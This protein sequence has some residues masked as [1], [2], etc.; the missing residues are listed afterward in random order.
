MLYVD[1]SALLKFY[2]RERGTDAMI[3]RLGTRQ[4]L[5]SSLLTFAEVHNTLAK[6]FLHERPKGETHEQARRA[7][8]AARDAFQ[9]DWMFSLNVVEMTT[10]TLSNFPSLV[11]RFV[12]LRTADAIQ[13]ASAIWLRDKGRWSPSSVEGDQNVE[14][15]TADRKLGQVARACG[16]AVFDPESA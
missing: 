16:F 5:F 8:E 14:F 2:L 1:T 3:E 12:E 4:R 11:E 15:V 13:L 6:R 7:L 9:L 10:Q